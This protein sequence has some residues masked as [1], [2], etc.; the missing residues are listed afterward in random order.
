MGRR[1]LSR[2]VKRTPPPPEALER[3]LTLWRFGLPPPTLEPRALFERDCPLELEVGCGTGEYLCALA[4]EHPERGYV[5]I[6]PSTKS[7]YF[8]V[9]LAADAGLSNIHFVRAPISAFYGALPRA[10]LDALY[11][12]FPDPF[13][14][15]RGVHKVL[16]PRFFE[17]LRG[18]LR[19]EA[20]LS[21]VSDSEEFFSEILQLAESAPGWTRAHAERFLLGFE[22]PTRS[23]YQLKWERWEITPRRIVLR[24]F[25]TPPR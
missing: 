16:N 9:R 1:G 7:L 21:I 13:V 24:R 19:E 3:Y 17:E 10:S 5:G 23:R 15:S 8:A 14:R 20:L 11:V 4:K 12:H 25:P 6:D 18:A 22:P 2:A